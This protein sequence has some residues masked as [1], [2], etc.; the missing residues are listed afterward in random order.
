M[1][2]YNSIVTSNLQLRDAYAIEIRERVNVMGKH[3]QWIIQ[4]NPSS[5]S[6]TICLWNSMEFS[7]IFQFRLRYNHNQ[8]FWHFV[9]HCLAT[10]Q[11]W[12]DF[13]E[14]ANS[15][16]IIVF[17][18]N[19]FDPFRYLISVAM[20]SGIVINDKPNPFLRSLLLEDKYLKNLLIPC[21][22]V[23]DVLL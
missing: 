9:L 4:V 17:D 10:T 22:L 1:I 16:H 14:S 13:T 2:K 15:A 21:C 3:C 23:A 19:R 5:V 20:F 8:H 18:K 6:T 11:W 12:N 7:Y